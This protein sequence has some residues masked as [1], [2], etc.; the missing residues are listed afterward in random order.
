M[1]S[2]NVSTG[3][4]LETDRLLLREIEDADF[5]ALHNYWST[6]EVWRFMPRGQPGE[7][8]TKKL[9]Q[10]AI[11]SRIARPRR[12]FRLAVT[13][14]QNKDLIGDCVCRITEPGNY[15]DLA[16]I[17]GQAY[18]GFFLDKNYWRQGYATEVAEA[19]LLLGFDRLRLQKIFAWCDTE[20]LASIRVLEKAGMKR[21]AHFRRSVHIQGEWR[22]CYVYAILSDEW[23]QA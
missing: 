13:L 22:D 15:E 6:R 9:V 8:V 20:N 11:S 7:E 21:E 16:V 12:Y 10:K 1:N 2:D 23:K 19:L 3:V 14:K 18:I 5:R 17:I 4:K